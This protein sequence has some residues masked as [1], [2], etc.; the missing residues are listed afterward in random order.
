MTTARTHILL[1]VMLIVAC[2]GVPRALEAQPGDTASVDAVDSGVTRSGTTQSGTT[3]SD[4]T[5]TSAVEGRDTTSLLDR[6]AFELGG[7]NYYHMPWGS[8][9]RV[10]IDPALTDVPRE[11]QR[12]EP[13]MFRSYA[14]DSP[15]FHGAGY[16]SV[17][18]TIRPFDGFRVRGE[19]V[20]EYRGSS[21][22]VYDTRNTAV[23]PRITF[24]FDT[25]VTIAGVPVGLGLETG[26]FV[27]LRF[28]QGLVLYNIDALATSIWLEV[29]K[30]RY[31][32]E[33]VGDGAYSIGLNVDDFNQDGIELRDL[34][35]IDGVSIRA[36]LGGWA[37]PQIERIAY[38]EVAPRAELVRN[39][40]LLERGY[41]ASLALTLADSL[42][43]YSE[44]ALRSADNGDRLA[45]R[46][47]FLAGTSYG[48]S[49]GGLTV[50]AS[51][52][53][54]FY[55]G[56]FNAGFS[57]TGVTYQEWRNDGRIGVG[58]ILYPLSGLDRPFSQWAVF[59]EYQD[60]KD[61]M[62]LTLRTFAKLRL[63]DGFIARGDLDLNWI[64]A[65]RTDGQL[66]PFF[67]VGVGWEPFENTSIVLS[68]TN[69]GMNLD[70]DYPTFY[71]YD[72]PL[73]SA[74]IRWNR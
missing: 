46:T 40:Q 60:L 66:Y 15:L 50:R 5:E 31:Y 68:L 16:L 37:Y 56:L 48:V 35:V 41:N 71:L 27:N 24:T 6:I 39:A 47:A 53:Y 9:P 43:L 12:L 32:Y 51:G 34:E 70:R 30:L 22:G 4:T 36:R 42:R 26:H 61:V 69:R 67:D 65:E 57:N 63:F 64:R 58:R 29:W 25:S 18:A 21:Y 13:K 28:G 62:G 54:R 10:T 20:G 55:G 59:T 3:Q 52:E 49:V 7:A 17:A 73:P 1:A 33:K 19:L 8:T 44:I 23:F 14:G 11:D 45:G 38:P 72:T 74:T 2:A